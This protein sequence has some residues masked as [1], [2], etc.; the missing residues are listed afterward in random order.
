MWVEEDRQRCAICGVREWEWG[1]Y[2]A[3]LWRC[4]TCADL[5]WKRG[6]IKESDS[7]GYRPILFGKGVTPHG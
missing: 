6:D 1:R 4:D 7:K 3:D 5:E 2:E